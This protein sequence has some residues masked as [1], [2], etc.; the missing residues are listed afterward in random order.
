MDSPLGS[1]C[2]ARSASQWRAEELPLPSFVPG[3]CAAGG[4]VVLLFTALVLD[5]VSVLTPSSTGSV[6]TTTPVAD[7][8]LGRG[9][10]GAEV[11]PFPVLWAAP[12]CINY[13]K[14]VRKSVCDVLTH[15]D[16]FWF[17]CF[18][19]ACD[20]PFGALDRT[21]GLLCRLVQGQLALIPHFPLA[22]C[23]MSPMLYKANGIQKEDKFAIFMAFLYRSCLIFHVFC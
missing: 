15:P 5:V 11:A 16:E 20:R 6:L 3:V 17:E 22:A 18:G 2:V 13:K 4:T 19:L 12:D 7:S 8:P 21:K 14:N 10:T 23:T 1:F 9:V